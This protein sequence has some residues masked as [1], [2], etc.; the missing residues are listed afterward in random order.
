MPG[1]D[2]L[3]LIREVRELDSQRGTRTPAA[4]LT[5]LARTEDRRRALNAGYQMHV[6]KPIDPLELAVTVE[7]LA[8]G[9]M[10]S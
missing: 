8:H 5:A 2:G 4:A 9:E 6:A 10:A 7:Q 1:E 3:Q